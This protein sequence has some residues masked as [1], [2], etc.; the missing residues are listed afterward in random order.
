MSVLKLLHTIVLVYTSKNVIFFR[1]TS[2]RLRELMR[3]AGFSSE[4]IHG[5]TN[6][7]LAE[8]NPDDYR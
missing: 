2:F 7:E 8:E 4:E 1:S 3:D 5:H 6:Q